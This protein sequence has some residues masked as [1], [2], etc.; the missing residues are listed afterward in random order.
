MQCRESTHRVLIR[1]RKNATPFAISLIARI[2]DEDPVFEAPFW[3][4]EVMIVF[5]FECES[6]AANVVN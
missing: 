5:Y 3:R 6:T 1:R 4:G 2:S